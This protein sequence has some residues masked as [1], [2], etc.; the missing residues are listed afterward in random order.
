M[1]NN[2]AEAW[3]AADHGNEAQK[4]KIPG[5]LD[6]RALQEEECG[7]PLLHGRRQGDL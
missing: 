4:A 5:F 2:S 1:E 3:R 7:H 6:L